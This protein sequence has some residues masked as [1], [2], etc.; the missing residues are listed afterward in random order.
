V[1]GPPFLQ[2]ALLPRLHAEQFRSLDK[3]EERVSAAVFVSE[4]VNQNSRLRRETPE[5]LAR[6]LA[7]PSG[8]EVNQEAV[9]KVELKNPDRDY[10]DLKELNDLGIVKILASPGDVQ[11]SYRMDLWVQATDNNADHD[12]G[13]RVTRSTDPI[14]LRVVSEGDLL[15][16]ISKEEEALGARLDEA[17]A[18][19]AAAK[20]AYEFVRQSNGYKEESPGVV[21]TV[22]S[23]SKAAVDAVDKARDIV[24]TV[25]REFRR[26]ARECQVNRVV[27]VTTKNYLDY[28]A[29][30]EGILSDDPAVEV[31]FPKTQK[32][33]NVVH[34]PL[35]AEPPNGR[36]APLAAVTD[37][38]M[39]LYALERELTAIR[40]A[41]GESLGKEQLIKSLRKQIDDQKVVEKQLNE[42]K[43]AYEGVL[44][45]PEPQIGA[46]GAVALNKGE[47][48]K[49]SHTIAWAKYKEDELAVKVSASDPSIVVPPTL[50][51]TFEN[52]QFRFDYDVK[53]GTTEGTFKVT[54]TPAV[55]KPV[56]VTV[57][58]K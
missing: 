18:Q 32:L 30:L 31:A 51:L 27:D 7:R 57:I 41:I 6:M 49:L 24:N 35:S 19:L 40:K 5:E 45:S 11:Q 48:K 38:E 39:S 25:L 13:P 12:G 43:V 55:G 37:A 16:E 28:C 9:R 29:R 52:H 23:K 34:A 58:V 17:L 3:N 20:R 36:W 1:A 14:R 42:L 8:D 56:E 47:T 53:A 46:L 50:T 2:S 44:L 4:F 26:I 33:L 10:F 21:S 54:L 15:L 22:A